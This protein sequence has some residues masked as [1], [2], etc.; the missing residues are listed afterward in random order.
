MNQFDVVK[1]NLDPTVGN[2]IKK[3]RPVV[4]ISPDEMNAN[5]GTI[6]IAPVTSIKRKYATRI[7][8]K[9]IGGH[10]SGSIALDQIRCI[11]KSRVIIQEDKLETKAAIQVKMVLRNMF[12]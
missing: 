12:A 8:C 6:I 9:T 4:V 11:D 3:T 10:V 1:V 2:E 7:E 5:L